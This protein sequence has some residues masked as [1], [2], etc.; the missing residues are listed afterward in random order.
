MGWQI[1]FFQI[2]ASASLLLAPAQ[3]RFPS[4]STTVGFGF[5]S[6]FPDYENNRLWLFGTPADRCVGNGN[7]TNVSA[8]WSSDLTTWETAFAFDFGHPTHNVQVT[9][10]G[11]MP[12]L[13]PHHPQRT[14]GAHPPASSGLPPHRYAM[15]LEC[16]SWAIN[17]K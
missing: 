5:V 1:F 16:F 7:P 2:A 4:P 13:P 15:F 9:R 3:P 17:N 8:W 14:A 10:V 6:A 12:G 11:P